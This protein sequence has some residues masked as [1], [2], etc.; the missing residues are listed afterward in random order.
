MPVGGRTWRGR[1]TRYRGGVPLARTGRM[2]VPRR[3]RRPRH[4]CRRRGGSRSPLLLAENQLPG[5][6]TSLRL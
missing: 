2:P 1:L 3:A 6:F 4:S 5:F